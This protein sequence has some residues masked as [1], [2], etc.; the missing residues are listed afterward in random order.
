MSSDNVD[1][2]A[3]NSSLVSNADK[4]IIKSLKTINGKHAE[5]YYMNKKKTCTGA[6]CYRQTPLDRWMSPT[7]AL[8]AREAANAL[9]KYTDKWEALKYLSETY[10]EGVKNDQK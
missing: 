7:N 1:F 9:K 10:P 3:K 2:I 4:E 5:V 6:F 8:D